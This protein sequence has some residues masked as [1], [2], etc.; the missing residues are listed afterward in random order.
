MRPVA[1]AVRFQR[2]PGA[3]R[4]EI[5]TKNPL[6]TVKQDPVLVD[7]IFSEIVSKIIL[8]DAPHLDIG[9]GKALCH[10]SRSA[11]LRQGLFEDLAVKFR[12]GTVGMNG[13]GPN[14]D[15]V[16]ALPVKRNFYASVL[17]PFLGQNLDS[18]VVILVS[19]LAV[20]VPVDLTVKDDRRGAGSE[21]FARHFQFFRRN[22]L[23]AHAREDGGWRTLSNGQNQEYRTQCNNEHSTKWHGQP[24]RA[25]ASTKT[26]P[27]HV[28]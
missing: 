15:Y 7:L 10:K 28:W 19:S 11:L 1:G 25:L 13:S 24:P 27:P 9:K 16:F 20:V 18:D 2:E 14:V 12:G 23:E 6:R 21:R 22:G 5:G 3:L 17:P 26:G 8:N 4:E